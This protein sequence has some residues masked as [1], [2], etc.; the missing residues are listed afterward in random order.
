MTDI[1]EKFEEVT[2]RCKTAKNFVHQLDEAHKRWKGKWWI[3]RGQ[4]DA[5]WSLMPKLFREWEDDTDPGYEIDLVDNFMQTVNLA[6]L[7]IPSNSMTY[8]NRVMTSDRFS[9]LRTLTNNVGHLRA[10]DFGHVAFALAQHSGIPTRLLDFTYSPLVAAY[11][12]ADI[13]NLLD[14]LGISVDGAGSKIL[15]ILLSGGSS[16]QLSKFVSTYQ[17]K[18]VDA[19]AQL[20]TEIAVWAIDINGLNNTTIELLAHPYHDIPNLRAQQGVCLCDM[21]NYEVRNEPWKPFSDRL[22]ALRDQRQILR[23]TLPFGERDELLSILGAKRISSIYLKPSYEQIAKIVV[24][25]TEKK[26]KIMD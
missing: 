7:P 2:I 4:N 1:D 3:Y 23:L 6:N 24:G 8:D 15:E 5:S 18:A 26:N 25:G 17:M 21:E 9:T 19:F 10:F 20:P 14:K 13:T 22:L 16:D 12:A 11:F